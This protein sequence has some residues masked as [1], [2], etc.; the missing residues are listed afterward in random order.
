[1]VVRAAQVAAS[2]V[3]SARASTA[4]ACGIRL[5]AD[6]P[7]VRGGEDGSRKEGQ[8]VLDGCAEDLHT[9]RSLGMSTDSQTHRL[10]SKA[11]ETQRCREK[12]LMVRQEGWHL[13]FASSEMA[14]ASGVAWCALDSRGCPV[15]GVPST[16]VE[17]W[18][19]PLPRAIK[20]V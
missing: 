9:G 20:P 11:P 7:H 2:T 17:C 14:V 4:Q 3:L 8:S 13:E 16:C 6:I 12:K 15:L 18:W 10:K 19:M 5:P 1:M